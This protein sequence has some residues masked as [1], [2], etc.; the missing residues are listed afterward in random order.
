MKHCLEDDPEEE[1]N[2]MEEDIE[3]GFDP[4]ELI[5]EV[6]GWEFYKKAKVSHQLVKR[7]C[8]TLD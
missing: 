7:Y 2:K 4:K 8:Q 5:F 3:A 1:K 6:D